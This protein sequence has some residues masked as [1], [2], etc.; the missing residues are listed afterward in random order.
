MVSLRNETFIVARDRRY[1]A[2]GSIGG[3]SDHASACGILLIHRHRVDRNPIER[4]QRI[5]GR[6]GTF[7]V[8]ETLRQAVRAAPHIQTAGENSFGRDSA[9][10]AIVHGL[11][12]T[13][14]A[15]AHA[16]LRLPLFARDERGLIPQ[17][18]FAD[19]EPV[20]FGEFQQLRGAVERIW[21]RRHSAAHRR[22]RLSR[23]GFGQRPL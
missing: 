21:D 18:E 6:A 8:D 10:D 20:S 5:G 14:D 15:G 2:R 7:L 17:H 13:I 19:A 23:R 9:F 16:F 3:R 22:R 1:H 12:D 4:G 11:P